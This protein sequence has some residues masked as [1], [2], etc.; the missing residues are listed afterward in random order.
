MPENRRIASKICQPAPGRVFQRISGLYLYIVLLII[1]QAFFG[2]F[3]VHIIVNNY[4]FNELGNA[5][6]YKTKINF[7]ND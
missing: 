5:G 1:F 6:H 7:L 3:R 4:V 2:H